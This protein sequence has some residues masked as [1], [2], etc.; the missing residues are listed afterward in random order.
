MRDY[1]IRRVK[2]MKIFI[3]CVFIL[4]YALI[5]ALPKFKTIITGVSAVVCGAGCLI[6]GSV[7]FKELFYAIDFNVV[8]MLL[9]KLPHTR[10]SAL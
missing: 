5:V 8:L 10:C 9:G 6:A 3:L 1:I 4:T 7:T 2:K